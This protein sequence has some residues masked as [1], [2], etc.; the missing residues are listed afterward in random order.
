MR[1]KENLLAKFENIILFSIF[2][3]ASFIEEAFVHILLHSKTGRKSL[4]CGGD[5]YV[6]G[7]KCNIVGKRFV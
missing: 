2:F 1:N 4:G 6:L 3:Y 5:I 7:K